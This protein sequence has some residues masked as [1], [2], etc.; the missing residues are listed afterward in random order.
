MTQLIKR[1]NKKHKIKGL[2]QFNS[3]VHEYRQKQVLRAHNF[4]K[5]SYYSKALKERNFQ[6]FLRLDLE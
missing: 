6:F 2:Y 4:S 5:S 1:R 3:Y